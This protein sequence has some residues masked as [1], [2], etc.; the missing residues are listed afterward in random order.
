MRTADVGTVSHGTMRTRDLIDA[1]TQHLRWL[2]G[3][4]EVYPRTGT[5]HARSRELIDEMR[6]VRVSYADRDDYY[7]S[8]AACDHLDA[9]FEILNEYAPPGHYFGAHEGDGSDYGFW[10]HGD[11]D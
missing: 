10:P 7:E 8:E 11:D 6:R 4:N 2:Y 3:L 1:F 5:L 9:L